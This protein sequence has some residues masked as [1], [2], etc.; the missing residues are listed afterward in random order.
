MGAGTCE[1]LVG[2]DGTIS[3]LEVNTR[4]QVEH[5]VSEE[6]TGLD[7]VREMFRIA[8][9]EELGYDDPEVRGHS[10]EFRINAEDGGATSCPPR[11]PDRAGARRAAPA[12]VST[13][14]TRRA[15]PSP[16]RSTRWSPS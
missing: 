2:Q 5:P 13:A 11:H 14:A 1:F 15:R 12:S 8:A 7:L 16:A 4:L 3:F 10:I 6:V 9:G